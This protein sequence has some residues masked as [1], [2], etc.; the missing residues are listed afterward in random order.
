MLRVEK[1]NKW[2]GCCDR[3]DFEG[4]GGGG[5]LDEKVGEDRLE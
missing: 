4:D 3:D 2:D 1:G 5:G